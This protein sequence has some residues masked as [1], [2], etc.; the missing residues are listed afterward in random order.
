MHCPWNAPCDGLVDACA[1]ARKRSEDTRGPRRLAPRRLCGYTSAKRKIRLTAAPTE[2]RNPCLDARRSNV[3]CTC[4]C[5]ACLP[6]LLLLHPPVH[7]HAT[8]LH[9][10]LPRTCLNKDN[11]SHPKHGRETMLQEQCEQSK[12][13]IH[14]PGAATARTSKMMAHR[15]CPKL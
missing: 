7:H 10:S 2:D 3:Y 5:D 4:L 9:G 11:K 1:R 15:R 8:A 14:L 6:R 13:G 12:Q